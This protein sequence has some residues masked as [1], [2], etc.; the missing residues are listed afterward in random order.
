MSNVLIPH[1]QVRLLATDSHSNSDR[2]LDIARAKPNNHISK[3]ESFDMSNVSCRVFK[4]CQFSWDKNW[5]NVWSERWKVGTGKLV[6]IFFHFQLNKNISVCG[7]RSQQHFLC[8][9]SE[10]LWDWFTVTKLQNLKLQ[11]NILNV[12]TLSPE[13]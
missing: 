8:C 5:R 2:E 10:D 3:G 13:K 1:P 7:L 6:L 11:S 9:N 12:G 4:V